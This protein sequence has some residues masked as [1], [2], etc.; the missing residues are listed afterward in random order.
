M[1][2]AEAKQRRKDEKK[3]AKG[4]AVE[5][6]QESE[7]ERSDGGGSETVFDGIS[8]VQGRA[9]FKAKIAKTKEIEEEEDV[10]IL[11]NRSL[12]S[13]RSVLDQADVILYILDARDPLSHRSSH[14]EELISAE[15]GTNALFI[16]NKIGGSAVNSAV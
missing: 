8:G 7:N 3:A 16:L 12:S 13:L 6:V 5:E 15:S 10:P 9:K 4:I 14:L 2:T 11:I 1:K